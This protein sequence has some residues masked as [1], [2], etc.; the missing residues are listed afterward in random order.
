MEPVTHDC[1]NCRYGLG[2]GQCRLNLEAEC[3]AGDYEAW[4]PKCDIEQILSM[5][6]AIRDE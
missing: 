4:E 2:G 1:W 6:E 3:A 5:T